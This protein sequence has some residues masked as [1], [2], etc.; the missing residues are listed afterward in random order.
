MNDFLNLSSS[1][2]SLHPAVV[3]FPIVLLIL[4]VVVEFM[5]LFF[6]KGRWEKLSRWL[7]PL[8][9]LSAFAAV[10]TGRQGADKLPPLPQEAEEVLKEHSDLATYVVVIFGVVAFF[11]FLLRK[12]RYRFFLFPVA[13]VGL[14]ILVF[15]AD[16]GGALVYR[17]QVFAKKEVLKKPPPSPPQ[18][19]I[20]HLP[21]E[22]QPFDALLTSAHFQDFEVALEEE[23]A[24]IIAIPDETPGLTLKVQKGGVLLLPPDYGDLQMEVKVEPLDFHGAIALVHHYLPQKGFHYFQVSTKGEATLGYRDAKGNHTLAVKSFSVTPSMMLT[25]TVAGR[26]LKGYKDGALAVHAHKN[27]GEKGQAGLW[28]QGS[29]KLKLKELKITPGNAREKTH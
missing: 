12:K 3:H 1:L 7:Y 5:D 14:G 2:P 16:H 15:T 6:L 23:E 24:S 8:G 21:E 18:P 13:L 27:P 17:Y 26:H 20:Q 4:A 11:R 9:F 29:G 19:P 28:F 25:L 22:V 10:I